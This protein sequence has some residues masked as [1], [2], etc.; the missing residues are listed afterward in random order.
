MHDTHQCP[1]CGRTMSLIAGWQGKKVKCPGCD[2]VSI[3][4]EPLP[5]GPA[6]EVIYFPCEE[7]ESMLQAVAARRGTKMICKKCGLQT[8]VPP[9]E[10][11]D[12]YRLSDVLEPIVDPTA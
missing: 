2:T 5:V 11:K 12:M 7:C 8:V 9:E 6:G 4:G 3:A 1:T 10:G